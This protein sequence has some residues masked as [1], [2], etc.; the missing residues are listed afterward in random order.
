MT[1]QIPHHV[2]L[3]EALAFVALLLI[4]LAQAK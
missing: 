1:S 2:W 3:W 4:F